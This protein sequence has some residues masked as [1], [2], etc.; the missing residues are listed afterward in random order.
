MK[1]DTFQ[2][3]RTQC[4][5]ENQVRYNIS[6]SGV[7]PVAVEELLG[8]AETRNALL[9]E[10]LGYPPAGGSDALRENIA[11]LYGAT[12][13]N[14]RVTNGSSEAN[15]M[16]FWGLLERGDRAAIML[17]NY[18]QTWG[19]A[20]H[21]VGQAD[22]Y[23]LVIQNDG[24][25][26]RWALDIDSL[27]HAARRQTKIIL[28]TNPNNPTGSTLSE[29]EVNEIIRTAGKVGA[30]IVADEVYRGAELSGQMT[31][32][33]YGKYERVLVTSGLSKA[34]GLPG[35]R[36][37]WIAGPPKVVAK[38][39]SYHDYLTLT[40]TMLSERLACIALQRENR[41]TLL[42]RTRDIMR[43]QLPV[44]ETWVR[45]NE[46][47]IDCILPRAGAIALLSYRPTISSLNLFE[48]LRKEKSVLI[49]PGAH[50]GLKGR[51]FRIGY[52]GDVRKLEAGLEIIST[53][54]KSIS[55]QKTARRISLPRAQ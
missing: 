54:L 44:V 17:P 36:I 30:W 53:F 33:F 29:S 6:E 27:H 14:I 51:Y 9:S 37:G 42:Q 20:R 48:R 11:E 25:G 2:M 8:T 13:A 21:F 19:L 24:A 7:T 16:Q 49:T 32:S 15:F 34:F 10:R 55:E 28:V 23:R 45:N 5:Y 43:Q 4:L 26:K 12:S 41:E 46:T 52:G 50:F 38:L 18:L 22:E 1:I 31:P 40:P 47:T 3:E 39:E 35:L